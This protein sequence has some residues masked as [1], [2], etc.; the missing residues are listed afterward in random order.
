MEP[1]GCRFDC[2]HVFRHLHN[3]ILG[4]F[5]L[6]LHTTVIPELDSASWTPQVDKRF[7]QALPHPEARPELEQGDPGGEVV[8]L[9]T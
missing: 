4:K 5:A 7:P 6:A 1:H 2:D 9:G 8:G 3:C